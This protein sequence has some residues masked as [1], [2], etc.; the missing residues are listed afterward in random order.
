VYR[1]I[2][3]SV[4][5][6]IGVSVYRCIGVS[7]YQCIGVSVY[8][9]IHM[10]SG[11]FVKHCTKQHANLQSLVNSWTEK[12]PEELQELNCE[13]FIITQVSMPRLNAEDSRAREYLGVYMH[14][15]WYDWA[16]SAAEDDEALLY[17]FADAGAEKQL[18]VQDKECKAKDVKYTHRKADLIA[19][20]TTSLLYMYLHFPLEPLFGLQ[21]NI[22]N[23]I[24]DNYVYMQVAAREFGP[25]VGARL[26][27]KSIVYYFMQKRSNTCTVDTLARACEK[28]V[29]Q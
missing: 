3:V 23:E 6:C 21:K 8:Q 26:Y 29:L 25:S 10:T 9:C 22:A 7:V 1:C 20:N 5:R 16:F 24:T 12:L 28:L 27:T 2:G 17:M 11:E 14:Y 19:N 18:H 15:D 13:K 4:Y